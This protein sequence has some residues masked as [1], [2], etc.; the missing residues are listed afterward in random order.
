MKT[1]KALL[2]LAAAI[3]INVASA[4]EVPKTF[5]VP[6]EIEKSMHY[7]EFAKKSHLQGFVA[8]EYSI[9]S[10]GKITVLN[11]NASDVKLAAFVREKLESTVISNPE[12]RGIYQSKFKFSFRPR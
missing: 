9:S 10:E 1:L 5:R 4:V 3:S 6:N 12:Y 11:M 7:P 8:V 2:I